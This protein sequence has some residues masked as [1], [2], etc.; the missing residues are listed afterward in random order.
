VSRSWPPERAVVWD[1]AHRLIPDA[2]AHGDSPLLAAL[3]TGADV[4]DLVALSQATSRRVLIQQ[5][6]IPSGIHSDELVFG[7]PEWPIVN[8]AFC[9][10]HPQGAR[11]NGPHR[12]AWYAGREI[13]TSLAE[14]AFH[15]TIELQET[16]FWHLSVVYHDFLADIHGTFHD[17]RGRNDRRARACLDPDSYERSQALAHD[18]LEGGSLG[19]V[20]PAVR[21]PGSEAVACFRPATVNN[22]RRGMR[23]RLTWN[24]PGA[25]RVRTEASARTR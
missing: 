18:L 4:E 8:A 13:E 19:V 3:A 20:Y 25:P 14:V 17:L 21:H 9:Y 10:P 1:G 12:G 24:Q 6:A 7:V 22:V 15:K 2:H 23:Y 11:F 16:D 5:G